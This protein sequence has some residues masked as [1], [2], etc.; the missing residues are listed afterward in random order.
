MKI[1]IVVQRYG[2]DILGGAENIARGLSEHLLKYYDIEV[3]T[4]CAKDY[5]TWKNIYKEGIEIID[6]VKVRRFKNLSI[7]GLM[8]KLLDYYIFKYKNI[9]D[10]SLNKQFKYIEAQ[11]PYSP[12]LIKYVKDHKDEYNVFLFFTYLYY[13][14]IFGVITVPEKSIIIPTAHNEAPIYLGIFKILFRIP[15]GIIYLS[16]DEKEFVEKTFKNSYIENEVIGSGV[17]TIDSDPETFRKK[18][19]IKSRFILYSGRIDKG[20]GSHIL[21][22]YFLKYKQKQKNDIKLVLIGKKY[23]D[24]PVS[25]DIIYL[26]YIPPNSKDIFDANKS[27]YVTVHPSSTESLCLSLLESLSQGTPVLVNGNC[28]VL[29]SHCLRSKSGYFYLDYNQ[30]EEKLNLLLENENL[31]NEMGKNGKEYI[32]NN[33]SWDKIEKRYVNFI[34]RIAMK[35]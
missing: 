30:F 32:N 11:G 3:L 24:I 22:D 9:R 25:D 16:E 14:T 8:F 15:K 20:K 21:I 19:N 5:S 18:H 27:A 17:D 10:V 7:R 2:K 4:T 26:G 29:K 31:R 28:T 6:G 1:G 13:P 12:E 35:I 33:Y 23:I 34:D